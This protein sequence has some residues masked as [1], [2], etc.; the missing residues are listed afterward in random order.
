MDRIRIKGVMVG[1]TMFILFVGLVTIVRAQEACEAIGE[2]MVTPDKVSAEFD[3]PKTK[4]RGVKLRVQQSALEIQSLKFKYG[5][6]RA[7]DEFKDVGTVQAG[8]ETKVFDAPGAKKVKITGI[9]VLFKFPHPASKG[10]VI[11]V[12]GCK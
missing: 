8:G 9:E 7:D 10:A 3:V 1:I 12:L 11:Q 6:V 4:I 2:K 5:G